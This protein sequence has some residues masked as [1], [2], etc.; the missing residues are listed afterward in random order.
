MKIDYSFLTISEIVSK[1]IRTAEVFSK[2][3]IDYCCGGNVKL[4]ELCRSNNIDLF[5]LSQ[6]LESVQYSPLDD[7]LDFASWKLDQLI[8]Y[9][10]DTHHS[11]IVQASELLISLCLKVSQAHGSL[12]P[13]LIK[14]RELVLSLLE[15]LSS[16]M[17]KEERVLFPYALILINSDRTGDRFPVSG[18]N[19]ASNPIHIMESEH[20]TVGHILQQIEDLSNHYN[21]PEDA[22]AYYRLLYNNLKELQADIHQHVHL[23]NNILFPGIIKLENKI[24]EWA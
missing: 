13:E 14:I 10:V 22:C 17:N 20:E 6:E 9:I 1:D 15:E 23:E 5:T 7:S 19:N 4:I 24:L 18:L 8:N 11:Y 2:Y 21:I 16:H 12:H 3:G